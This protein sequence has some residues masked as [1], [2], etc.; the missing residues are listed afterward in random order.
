MARFTL[1]EFTDRQPELV[2]IAGNLVEAERVESV[3]NELQ[4]DYAINIESFVKQSFLGGTYPGAFF[5]VSKKDAGHSR[6]GLA[7]QGFT[8][9]IS[10]DNPALN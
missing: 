6:E 1:E 4:I 2:Y 9:T 3:F 8:D 10:S 7:I 5:Y